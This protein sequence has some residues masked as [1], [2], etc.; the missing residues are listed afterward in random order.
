MQPYITIL[1][2]SYPVYGVI[3]SLGLLFGMFLTIINAKKYGFTKEFIIVA[4]LFAAIFMILISKSIYFL[5]K[6]FYFTEN[7]ESFKDND[8]LYKINY[9][10]GGYVFYGGL[11]GI[12]IGLY[13][14]SKIFLYDSRTL[15]EITAPVIPLIHAFGRIGC[16]YGG[17]CYGI[18]YDGPFSISFNYNPLSP[19]LHEFDRF[20]VQLLEALLNFLLFIGLTIYSRK[21]DK[22]YNLM[23]VYLL[24]YSIIRFFLEF[25]RGDEVRGEII[26][27]STSQWISISILIILL[28][29]HFKKRRKNEKKI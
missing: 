4:D 7:Y 28:I 29:L 22:K 5:T 9:L 8:L 21:K 20:P 6:I 11:I 3:I 19:H 17:C 26:G 23:S 2:N 24:F 12:L 16:F 15:F 27:I 18:A 13:I 14:F 10:T 1:G 25:L